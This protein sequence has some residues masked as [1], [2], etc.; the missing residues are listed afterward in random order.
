MMIDEE[1]NFEE[2]PMDEST[3]E[4]KNLLST[5]KYAFLDTE[6]AKPVIISSQPDKEHEERLL[7][8]LR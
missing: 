4:L 5:L 6:Q 1:P 8:V 7:E 3:L 2:L